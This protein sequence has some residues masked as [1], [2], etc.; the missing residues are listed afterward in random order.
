[1]A[2]NRT[3]DSF[4]FPEQGAFAEIYQNLI[5]FHEIKNDSP[6]EVIICWTKKRFGKL[7]KPFKIDIEDLK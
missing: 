6:S 3:F 7:S 5:K 1:M 2:V 4:V